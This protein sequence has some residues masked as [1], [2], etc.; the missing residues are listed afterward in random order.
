MQFTEIQLDTAFD[1]ICHRRRNYPDHSDV[2]HLRHHWS[3]ERVHLLERLHNRRYQLSPLQRVQKTSGE[4]IHLWSASDALVLKALSITLADVL[5]ISLACTHIKGH[6]GLKSTIQNIYDQLPG[7]RFVLRTDVKGYYESIDHFLLMEQLAEH[8]KD[9][10]ILNLLWQYLHRMVERG[11]LYQEVQKGISRGCPLS[12]LIGAFFLTSLDNIFQQNGLF[13][14]RYMDD[15]LI[16]ISTRWKLR[17]AVKR[18]NETFAALKLIKHPGKTFI[19]KVEKGFDFLGYHF[20]SQSLRVAD[21][22]WSKFVARLHQ[23]YEQ[24]RTS[25]DIDVLLGVYVRRWQRWASAGLRSI[26][27]VRNHWL[28]TPPSLCV[29]VLHDVPLLSMH[30]RAV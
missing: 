26:E 6:G 27:A 24:E 7:Y 10:F 4:V 22:T 3:R 12:P 15:I 23:L 28:I 25:Q 17:R 13:Y 5:P 19:G 18:L 11:S 30:G 1:W 9:K 20:S 2:W 8:I 14:V 16:M 29:D 21:I